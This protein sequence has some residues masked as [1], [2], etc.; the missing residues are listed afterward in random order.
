MLPVKSR[1]CPHP[2]EKLMVF[3]LSWESLSARHSI[4]QLHCQKSTDGT[5]SRFA[6]TS[7]LVI[8]LGFRSRK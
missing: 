3:D 5:G 8:L 7:Y 1:R 4:P 2:Q 6:E